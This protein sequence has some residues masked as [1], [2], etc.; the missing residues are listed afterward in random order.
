MR[1]FFYSKKEELFGKVLVIIGKR[2]EKNNR[3]KSNSKRK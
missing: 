1:M 2:E 3:L